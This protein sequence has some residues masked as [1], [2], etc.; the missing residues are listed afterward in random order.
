MQSELS[1]QTR[2]TQLLGIRYPIIQGGMQWV[3]RAEL[4]AAVSNA[5]GLGILTA[6]TQPTPEY[7]RAEIARCRTMTQQPFG[8]NL[9]MLPAAK[10]PPYAEYLQVALD[11]EVPVL[12]TAGNVPEEFI[13]RAR[14]ANV[15]VLHKCTSVRHALAAERRGVQAISIDSFECAGHPGEDDIGA[16][17]LIPAAAA[18]VGIPLIA[19]GGIGSGRSMA[20]ALALG[21]DGVN[22][23]T[24]FCATV[25]APIHASIKLLLV[26][27]SERDTQ[28]IFRTLRNTGRVLRNAISEEVLGLERR[29]GGATF[30][31]IQPLVSG[32]RGKATLESGEVEAGLIWAGQVIGLIEDIPTCE[33]LI[34]RIVTECRE[35]LRIASSAFAPAAA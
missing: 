16:M 3:G 2:I 14:Q 8:V 5:G 26:S 1:L 18:K 35:R 30:A 22:M 19:S 34:Q 12:E 21:A 31:D 15:K 27:R 11:S 10:P 20:A 9:T 28:L 24:R 6:L 13:A 4:A 33:T 32:Q 17:V 29:A 25:E 23:G 7:L